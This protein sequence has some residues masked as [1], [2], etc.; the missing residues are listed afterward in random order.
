MKITKCE[1]L[2]E[3]DEQAI[4]N[5]AVEKA[6]LLLPETV[7][8]LIANHVALSKMNTQFYKD[9]PEFK[10]SKDV[11]AQV[12]EMMEGENPLDDYETLLKKSV[13]KIRERL[14]TLKNLDTKNVSS[15]PNRDFKG[16][17]CGD[18]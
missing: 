15:N 1:L 12:V 18:I 16:T 8:H 14:L 11:V 6:L 3:E 7:G 2:T 5:L 10:D 4:V 13:P 17:G 9:H